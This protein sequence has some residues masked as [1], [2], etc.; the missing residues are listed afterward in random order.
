LKF[1]P[2]PKSNFDVNLPTP[3]PL[4]REGRRTPIVIS[5][6]YRHLLE[7]PTPLPASREGSIFSH[8]KVIVILNHVETHVMQY[9]KIAFLLIMASLMLWT[10][11]WN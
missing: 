8:G 5:K 1:E 2:T 3:Y 11:R 4:E 9:F 7:L 10:G 6:I